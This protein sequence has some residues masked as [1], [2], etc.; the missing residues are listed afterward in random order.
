MSEDVR[1][2]E[3]GLGVIIA[4]TATVLADM[5]DLMINKGLFTEEEITER[6]QFRIDRSTSIFDRMVPEGVLRQLKMPRRHP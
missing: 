2:L 4:S 6:L 1:P 3:E 5:A